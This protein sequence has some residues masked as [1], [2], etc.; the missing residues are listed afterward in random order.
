M[1]A[2]TK[3]NT[4]LYDTFFETIVGSAPSARIYPFKFPEISTIT[5]GFIVAINEKVD[6]ISISLVNDAFF[7][8]Y[9]C[10]EEI[11][12]GSFMA[13]KSNILTVAAAGNEGPFK[14]KVKNTAP[15]ILTVG[16]SLS[17]KHFIAPVSIGDVKYE[18]IV[19]LL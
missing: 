18:V 14:G 16:A 19:F 8:S 3:S 12:V 13:M 2:A 7:K 1:A 4:L 5:D 17:E 9:N 15:W 10:F 11:T 6:V